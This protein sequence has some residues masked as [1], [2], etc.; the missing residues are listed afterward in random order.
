M[1]DQGSDPEAVRPTGRPNAR[2]GQTVADMARSLIVVLVVVGAILLVTWRPAPDPIRTV[3]PGPALTAARA[4]AD[5]E[6]LYPADLPEGWLITSARW[7]LPEAADPDPAWHLGL[8][9]P[10][11][12][13][14]QLGQSATTNA[15][16]I[17]EQ[18]NGGSP[19]DGGTGEWQRYETTTGPDEERTR[20]MVSVQAGVTIVVGG[21]ADWGV[22][23]EFA[24]R[25][26]PTAV[27]PVVP[28]DIGDD[29]FA[30]VEPDAP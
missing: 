17:L 24:A 8:V 10:Q 22:L 11:E 16:Y 13:Y 3:D 27:P 9:D 19:V 15:A 4:T 26:S 29:E 18:T 6:V 1:T 20:S 28:I 21:T 7:D 25:L 14:V 23:E 30:T 12:K 2:L 5:F